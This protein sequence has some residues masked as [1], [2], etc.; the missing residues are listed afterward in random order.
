MLENNE[1]VEVYPNRLS[2]VE[3]VALSRGID[4]GDESTS[5]SCEKYHLAMRTAQK[6]AQVVRNGG[7]LHENGG[8]PTLIDSVW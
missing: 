1:N 5:S 6:Y 7:A 4:S 3:K 2:G 8:R